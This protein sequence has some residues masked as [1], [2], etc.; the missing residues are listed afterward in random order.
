MYFTNAGVFHLCHY[1]GNVYGFYKFHWQQNSKSTNSVFYS[2]ILGLIYQGFGL[3]APIKGDFLVLVR[4]E[5]SF[6]LNVKRVMQVVTDAWIMGR[7]A[8]RGVLFLSL[9]WCIL[10]IIW[11]REF[12]FTRLVSPIEHPSAAI[13]F[14]AG[15]HF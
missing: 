3:A 13:Q 8:E 5:W 6:S 1:V 4:P 14:G 2:N 12:I 9:C 11:R 7:A 15:S 10:Y